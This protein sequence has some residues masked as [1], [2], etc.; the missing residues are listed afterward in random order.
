VAAPHLTGHVHPAAAAPS[1]AASAA[2]LVLGPAL[3]TTTALWHPALTR[4]TEQHRV[5]CVDLPG[6]GDSPAARGAFTVADL[7]ASVLELIDAAAAET[8][9]FAGAGMSGTIG[10]QLA[11]DGS[12]RMRSLSLV[13]SEPTFGGDWNMRAAKA[14]ADGTGSL[15]RSAAQ[16]WFGADFA[17]REPETVARTVDELVGV[18]DESYAL[19]CEAAAQYDRRLGLERARELGASGLSAICVDGPDNGMTAS[20]P[21]ERLAREL[22]ATLVSLDEDSALPPLEAPS[23]LADLILFLEAGVDAL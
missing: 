5:L 21:L 12:R 6:H 14:R 16:A 7:A 11:R 9:R 13:S 4:L 15:A 2:L 18:D 10:L 8:F 23:Q 19:C 22:G 17:L 1:P 20:A 3:G